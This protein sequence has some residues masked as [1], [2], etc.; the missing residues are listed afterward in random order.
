MA[1]GR[2]SIALLSPACGSKEAKDKPIQGSVKNNELDL[3]Q[4]FKSQALW[5][6]ARAFGMREVPAKTQLW[7]S[8]EAKGGMQEAGT[9]ATHLAKHLV[10]LKP[11]RW[12]FDSS[13]PWRD[14]SR[15]PHT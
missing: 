15:H 12:T 6:K 10:P 13:A 8:R 4:L 7:R 3:M 11:Q 2:I 5:P 9:N 14:T 1:A